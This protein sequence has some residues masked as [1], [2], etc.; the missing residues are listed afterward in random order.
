[1]S[2]SFYPAYYEEAANSWRPIPGI[3]AFN[4]ANGSAAEFAAVL[5]MTLEAGIV[6]ATPIATLEP[7]CIRYLQSRV[8]RPDAARPA[9]VYQHPGHAQIIDCGRR[10]GYLQ[11][12]VAEFLAL[13][14]EGRVCGATHVYGA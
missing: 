10:E 9:R 12:R 7:R 8:G 2:I 3:D 13:I 14:R 4:L 5:G 1:M 11:A 6:A